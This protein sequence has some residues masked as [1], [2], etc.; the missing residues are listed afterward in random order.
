MTNQ[1]GNFN[2]S[3]VFVDMTTCSLAHNHNTNFSVK[4]TLLA[5]YKS[6]TCYK[7]RLLTGG[8]CEH[9]QGPAANY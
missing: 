2:F 5:K 6:L 4:Q 7:Y 3:S 1:I 8:F 9:P